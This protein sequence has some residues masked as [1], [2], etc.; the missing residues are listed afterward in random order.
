MAFKSYASPGK[1]NPRRVQDQTGK[2]VD[3]ANENRRGMEDVQR[4]MDR[5]MNAIRSTVANSQ[6]LEKSNRDF[7]FQQDSQNKELA[8][9]Q[10]MRNYEINIRNI[11]T[12][13]K[14]S[15]AKQAEKPD[16]MKALAGLSET[17]FKTAA[18]FV[19]NREKGLQEAYA[20]AVYQTGVTTEE[21]TAIIRNDTAWT[22]ESYNQSAEL[23][24]LAD[25][26]VS[27]EML[28]FLQKTGQGGSNR[29]MKSK[30]LMQNTVAEAPMAMEALKDKPFKVDGKMISYNEAV[31]AGEKSVAESL[32]TRI[33]QDF[34]RSSGLSTMSPELIGTLAYPKIR[35]FWTQENKYLRADF[36]KKAKDDAQ[37]AMFRSF[38]TQYGS[39]GITGSFQIV[40]DSTNRREARENW[41][42]WVSNKAKTGQLSQD[43]LVNISKM[44]VTIGNQTKTFK[45]W[46]GGTE[47]YADIVSSFDAGYRRNR[48]VSERAYQESQTNARNAEIEIAEVLTNNPNLTQ[49]DIDEA[50]EQL[51]KQFPGFSFNRL[52][53]IQTVSEKRLAQQTMEV[54]SMA[55]DG[56]LTLEKLSKYDYRI[57]RKFQDVA[58]RNSKARSDTNN[59]KAQKD[60]IKE[61]VKSQ[62]FVSAAKGASTDGGYTV[63]LKTAELTRKFEKLRAQLQAQYPDKDSQDIANEAV[64]Q[65]RNEFLEQVN[66]PEYQVKAKEAFGYPD[67]LESTIDTQKEALRLNGRLNDIQRNMQVSGGG[68]LKNTGLIVNS[69]EAANITKEYGKPGWQPSP[70]VQYTA[71]TLGITPVQVINSQ[72]EALNNNTGT[73]YPTIG[74]PPSVQAVQSNVPAQVNQILSRYPNRERSVRRMGASNTFMPETVP[75]GYGQYFVES[76]GRYGVPATDL[77]ALAEIESQ[78]NVNAV[79][80]TGA[81]G[82]MQIQPE[83][84]PE[85][86]WSNKPEEQIDYGAKYYSQLVQ[87]FGD[88]VIAAGAYNAGP[89]RMKEHIETGRPLPAETVEHMKRFK[90]A[91][92]KYG[93]QD[94]LQDPDVMRSSSPLSS[95]LMP[96]QSY[97]EQ[98]SSIT[99]DNNQPGMDIFFE[100]HNFPAVLPGTVKDMGAQYNN[101]G[102][103]YGNFMVIESMDP[104][105]GEM[106]DVLYS[107]LPEPPSQYIG[108]N[109][110]AGEIIGKQGGTGSV[111][112]YDGTI[113]SIDF[114]APAPAGSGSMTPYSNFKQLRQ[115]IASQLR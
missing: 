55:E 17:A 59:Y 88:P 113:A 85:Y 98:V 70:L 6:A 14:N 66:T 77:A 38:E 18:S 23:N 43:E 50:N 30:A 35:S 52:D 106:V 16:N 67:M 75:N 110:N 15:A 13:A 101:D 72:I 20:M 56:S 7:I 33:S 92:Y 60:A 96:L 47:E 112:S 4:A 29:Y 11:E 41:A 78:F 5:N 86:Q 99:M 10:I 37:A 28:N 39:N 42:D 89:G 44:P 51:K 8:R 49:N 9:K 34:I 97:K 45:E 65:I 91:Q 61:L 40:T 3:R 57:F 26:G 107:H 80:P 53:D 104:Q 109:I 105:T 90:I 83:W 102:S 93:K 84:H 94:V 115:R 108:Q 69:A 103:G 114:L 24:R 2:M 46:Y 22:N 68:V 36:R 87:E 1:F 31:A 95:A 79:S 58:N 32:Q 63:P 62:T 76:S 25:A 100:D 82:I 111:Q 27:I 21:M 73:K 64:S 81:S 48:Q 19:E 74:E 71:E 12:E 54:A